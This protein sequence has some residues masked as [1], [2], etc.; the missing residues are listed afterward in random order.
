[1]SPRVGRNLRCRNGGLVWFGKCRDDG[2]GCGV[3]EDVLP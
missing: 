1:M 3:G 2:G